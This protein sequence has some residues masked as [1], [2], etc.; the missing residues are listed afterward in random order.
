ML[1]VATMPELSPQGVAVGVAV[2]AGVRVGV[3]VAVGGTGRVAVAAGSSAA[4]KGVSEGAGGWAGVRVSGMAAC[5][6]PGVEAKDMAWGVGVQA[7]RLAH[8]APQSKAKKMRGLIRAMES[9]D[10][11]RYGS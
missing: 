9:V 6:T 10:K 7:A 5:A 8:K 11:S 3:R 4:A 2:A 1:S